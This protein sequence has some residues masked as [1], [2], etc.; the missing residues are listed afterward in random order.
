MQLMVTSV[1]RAFTC[2]GALN[3]PTP[4]EI[5]SN[6]VSDDPPLAKARNKIKIA[7]AVKSPCSC[8]NSIAPGK[9]VSR[10]GRV[11][12]ESLHKPV[13]KTINMQPTKK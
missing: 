1:R 10:T 4:S 2:S 13:P 11:P 6:P 5:A 3:S 9:S 7:A 8:P 12:V